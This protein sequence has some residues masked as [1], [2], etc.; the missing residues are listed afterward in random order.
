MEHITG[1]Q[2]IDRIIN[3]AVSLSL[4]QLELL[5]KYS[6]ELLSHK[7]VQYVLQEAWFCG[8]KFYVDETVL[9]PR[10]ETEEMVEW[11]AENVRCTMD[12][13][14]WTTSKIPVAGTK[15]IIHPTSNILHIID[16]GTG[17]GCIPVALKKKLPGAVIYS[18]DV[19]EGALAVARRNASSNNTDIHFLQLDFL[20][21]TER[22]PLPFVD[23]IISNPPYIPSQDKKTMQANVVDFEP[24]L[25]LFVSDN[26]PLIFYEAI[27]DFARGKTASGWKYLRG[28]T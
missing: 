18:C 21:A 19:S 14:R 28:N 25:A 2:K 13:G 3:K 15:D 17:S 5:K 22:S 23:I 7:P 27:T 16:I 1:W 12:D 11:T 9:I 10:P 20:D 4:P 6:T 26:N 8:M 24:H